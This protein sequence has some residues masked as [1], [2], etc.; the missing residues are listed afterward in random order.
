MMMRDKSLSDTDT[1]DCSN[2]YTNTKN[3]DERRKPLLLAVP[4]L[5]WSNLFQSTGGH[6]GP[7]TGS[8]V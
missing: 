7:V 2:F 4:S 6:I 5:G 8:S 1:D 3:Y